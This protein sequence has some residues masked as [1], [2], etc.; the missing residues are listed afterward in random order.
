MGASPQN[1][2]YII[3]PLVEGLDRPLAL[4]TES[5]A[6]NHYQYIH[7]SHI[8]QNVQK[9]KLTFEINS[10]LNPSQ[11]ENA[12]QPASKSL[13]LVPSSLN[14]S[15]KRRSHVGAPIHRAANQLTMPCRILAYARRLVYLS[16]VSFRHLSIYLTDC[17]A[18]SLEQLTHL[19]CRLCCW[20]CFR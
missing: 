16:R 7:Y 3:F 15:L 11:H 17:F 14:S 9:T 19:S 5:N 1:P 18:S 4:P 10:R 20:F 13:L 12:E 2:H 6:K 8:L